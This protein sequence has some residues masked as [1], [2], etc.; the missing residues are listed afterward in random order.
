MLEFIGGRYDVLVSTTIIENG[1]DIPRVNTLVVQRADQFGLAQLYQLRGRVG[2]SSRQAFAYFLVPPSTDLTGLARKR[3]EAL[4]EFSELGSGFRLA[5]K[6]LEIRGA[7]HLFGEQQHGVMAAVGYDYFIHLLEGAIKELKGEAPAESPSEIHLRV[8]NRI[9]ETYLP[10]TN[11]RLNLYKRISAAE[12]LA[13]LD[14]I[15]GEVEDRFGPRPPGVDH[16]L[17]Y[18]RIK[19]LAQKL[20]I[21]SVERAESRL[22]LRFRPDTDVPLPSMTRLL[23]ARRGSMTPDGVL[24]LPLRAPGDSEL[25]H[26]T[27]AVL[28]ELYG[29]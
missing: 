20:K 15:A 27:I 6:D 29:V 28:K 26:E 9:P 13:V 21:K 14:S 2:R 12:S 10:Q 1:I 19:L 22:L 11:L 25:L 3:L 18:G 16:L 17:D 23:N 8:D 5:M 7:G 4:K 24:S